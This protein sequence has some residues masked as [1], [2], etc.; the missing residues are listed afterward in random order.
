MLAASLDLGVVMMYALPAG[1][2]RLLRWEQRMVA[3]PNRFSTNLCSQ[4]HMTLAL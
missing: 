4:H 1:A 2:R 3:G